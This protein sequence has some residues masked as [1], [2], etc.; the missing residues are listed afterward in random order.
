MSIKK[1]S[2]TTDPKKLAMAGRYFKVISAS[3]AIKLRFFY[4]DE[5][6]LETELYQGLGIKHPYKYKSFIVS[7]DTPQEVVIF[8]S[9]AELIDDRS[10]TSLTGAATLESNKADLLTNT[11]SQI[12]PARLGRQS[13]MIQTS[14][15]LYIGGAN[16][17]ATNGVKV[18]AG[19]AIEINTQSAI[20]GLSGTDQTVRIL[21]EVN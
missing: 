5:S 4:E 1:I 17:D 20:Y 9:D 18:D 19:E 12:V 6:E 14:D 8:A 2:V 7:A 15:V 21:E 13:V 16:L 3:G 10:E 11:V